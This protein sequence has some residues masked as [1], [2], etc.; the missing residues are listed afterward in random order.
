MTLKKKL[1]LFSVMINMIILIFIFSRTYFELKKSIEDSTINSLSASVDGIQS[2]IVFLTEVLKTR[3]FD[4]S[5]DSQIIAGASDHEKSKKVKSEFNLLEYITG[6]KKGLIRYVLFIDIIDLNGRVISSTKKDR[7]GNSKN[8]ED[9]FKK[10]RF[11]NKK[12]YIRDIVFRKEGSDLTI[13]APIMKNDISGKLAGILAVH[14]DASIIQK[15]ISGDIA[16][17]LEIPDYTKIM[18]K[19]GEIYLVN[20]VNEKD[21]VTNEVQVHDY[22]IASTIK[23][24]PMGK[25]ISADNIRK[26]FNT[27]DEIKVAQE[28][29]FNNIPIL[30]IA[31]SMTIGDF[32]WVVI[33]TI[34]QAEALAPI[35]A[36]KRDL[37]LLFL[38]ITIIVIFINIIFANS[39]FALFAASALSFALTSSS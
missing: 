39:L 17:D 19:T 33:A 5:T 16:R 23:D 6:Y 1:I 3:V 37:A 21:P 31:Q 34:S 9:Y 38:F 4:L 2:E 32:K 35:V 8:N 28:K 13:S 7:I 14:F 11:D 22:V 29:D 15:L 26:A 20:E 27:N 36:M 25:S 18:G 24:I 10:I 12:F 30:Y